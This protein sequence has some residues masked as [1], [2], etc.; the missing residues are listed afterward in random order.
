[1][2][3]YRVRRASFSVFMFLTLVFARIAYFHLLLLAVPAAGAA[4]CRGDADNI[5]YEIGRAPGPAKRGRSARAVPLSWST[6]IGQA[7]SPWPL[8]H[9]RGSL[10]VGWT[11]ALW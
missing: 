3:L 4:I 7:L 11:P 6:R 10:L 8:E 2:P 5:K 1:M 9:V